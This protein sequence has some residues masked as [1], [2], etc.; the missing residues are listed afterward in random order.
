MWLDAV[1]FV[2]AGDAE[3][4]GGVMKQRTIR[5]A[6]EGMGCAS[7]VGKIEKSLSA[8]AG[9]ITAHVN[10][11][12]RTASVDVAPD[13]SQANIME[14]NIIAAIVSAG[15]YHAVVIQNAADERNK[16]EA[17]RAHLQRR[18]KQS[19]VAM[20][21]GVP[22]M[23][24]SM[25]HL[26]PAPTHMSFWL[27]IGVLSFVVMAYSGSHFFVGTFNGLMHG[28]TSMDTL[29]AMGTGMAWI[30]SMLVVV[31][32]T[33]FPEAS[34]HVYFE[35]ALIVIALVNIGHVLEARARGQTNLAI[36][37]LMTLQAKTA[38]I[39]RDDEA[40]EVAIE[41]VRVGDVV[42]VRAGERIP[43]DGLVSQGQTYVDESMLTGEPMPVAKHVGDAVVAGTING[44]GSFYY[45]TSRIGQDTV[46]A[47][48]IETVRR[49]Q[50][51]KPKIA[52]TVDK[53][54]SVF[55]PAVL[56]IALATAA[57]WLMYDDQGSTLALVTA[58]S[59]VLIACPCALGLATP[60][61]MIVGIGKAAEHGIL[62]RHGGALEVASHLTTIVFDKTGTITLGQAKVTSIITGRDCSEDTVLQLAAAVEQGSEHPLA[63][64]IVDAAVS[65]QLAAF[66]ATSFLQV[67][68]RG[69]SA[70]V[71]D[72]LILLGNLAWMRHHK[73]EISPAWHDQAEALASAGNTPV[74]VAKDHEL[75]AMLAVA[76]P[77]KDDALEALLALKNR[78]LRL[79]MLTGD[80]QQTAMA[81]AKA[82]GIDDVFA[83]LKPE[84]KDSIIAKL[85]AEGEIVGMVGDGIND[86]A[87]LARAN[88]GFAIAQ[89]SDIAIESADVVLL[90]SNLATIPQAMAISQ[91]T[92]TNIKQNLWGAFIYNTLAIPV[93][94]GVLFPAFGLL[95]NP[96][97][98]GAAMALSS[99]T[100]VSN[101][102]RLRFFKP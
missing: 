78:G 77:I 22:L 58:M 83:E 12:D 24:L 6:I 25:M 76:D 64:A 68:G 27:L 48:I 85:Q 49:A 54:A 35:A 90:R 26:L 17:E 98:A 39:Q 51:A 97:L 82:V 47:H 96:M 16:A 59:V 1:R 14:A 15:S 18:I 91:A 67:A 13:M 37:K 8:T 3:T 4:N 57:F 88:V 2:G 11:A 73:V 81:V 43:V 10:L 21:T 80:H 56:L 94:A 74:F 36:E 28:N 69:A 89:G 50:S 75:I 45:T 9:V 40:M 30:Y 95:L 29:V 79:V 93:A 61:S 60:I 63:K 52:R 34:R 23:L 70:M 84:D 99:V 62:L 86:A 72:G 19:A 53:V 101:A 42:H 92:L 33:L 55:V 41:D 71:E 38:R 102:N 5:L 7:C 87:A 66:E 65:R 31:S 20:L 46:L 32:P 100:V 44:N